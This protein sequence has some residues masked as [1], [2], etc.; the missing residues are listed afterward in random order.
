[1]PIRSVG[2]DLISRSSTYNAP[3]KTKRKR[4][5]FNKKPINKVTLDQARYIIDMRIASELRR[6]FAE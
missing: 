4:R 1:M 3:R 5:Q 6:R 2:G